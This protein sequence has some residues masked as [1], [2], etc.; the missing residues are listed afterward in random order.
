MS[1]PRKLNERNK[2]KFGT[3]EWVAQHDDRRAT[4]RGL[5]ALVE[6]VSGLLPVW[7]WVI[8]LVVVGLLLP[9]LAGNNA[10]IRVAAN[11][12][13]MGLLALGL[14]IVVGYAGMLDLGFVAFYG[15]GAYGYAYLSSD[16]TGLH[17]PTF[18]TIPVV[19]LVAAGFGLLLGLPSLRL[20]G[21][22]LAI[23]TLGFG[24]IFVQLTTSL[25]RVNLPGAEDPINLTGGPNGIVNLDELHLFSLSAGDIT[26]YYYVLLIALALGLLAVHHMNTSRL[27]RAWRSMRE[28]ELAAEAMG[29][30]TRRLKLQAFS[31]GAAIAGFSGALFAAMQGAVFPANFETVSL[32]TLYAIIVLG[33]LGSLLGV[34]LGALVMIAV[35]E[36]LR[37]IEL[38]GLFFYTGVLLTLYAT[39]KP[40][41]QMPLLLLCVA[42]LGF[43]LKLILVAV[44]PEA[45]AVETGGDGLLVNTIRDLL[46]IPAEPRLIGNLGFGVLIALALIV[47]RVK[48]AVYRFALL[49]PTL[50]L[51]AF[52]WETRLSQEASVTRLLFVGVLLIVLMI[53]RPQGLLGQ[54]RVEVV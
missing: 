45:L 3:D 53:Y 51:T 23:V 14:N 16:F 22:Y 30:P 12:A 50:Y 20:V 49:I 15:I 27:G 28:D 54:R 34:L 38:A 37:N 4:S 43:I 2:Q 47:S 35:P 44:A 40:R 1:E 52:V 6:R 17:L 10:V 18:V 48:R 31:I 21:D 5:K 36:V 32:I 33:G 26:S 29:M 24:L 41:W 42:V 25:T 46:A 8:V 11:I 39:L 7:G 9:L 19:T 13:L